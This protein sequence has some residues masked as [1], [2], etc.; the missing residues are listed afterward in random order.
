[1]Q[2][3]SLP[4]WFLTNDGRESKVCVFVGFAEV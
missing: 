3:Y 1:M 4:S 2:K